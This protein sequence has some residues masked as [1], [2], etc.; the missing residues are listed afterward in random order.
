M[1]PHPRLAIVLVDHEP[2]ILTLLQR[3]V[4]RLAPDYDLVPILDGATALAVL[5]RLPVALITANNQRSRMDGVTLIAALRAIAPACPI[6]LI[7]GYPRP[8]PAPDGRFAGADFY[9]PKPIQFSQLA[10]V[11]QMALAQKAVVGEAAQQIGDQ[12]VRPISL[13]S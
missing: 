1:R 11:V 4:G 12:V 7:S 3:L 9:V 2:V 13:S 6:V 10:A 5:A 8:A